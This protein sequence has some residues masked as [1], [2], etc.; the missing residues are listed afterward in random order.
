MK[1]F[2]V[3]LTGG[4]S[5]GKTIASKYLERFFRV[6]D[7]DCI[8][9]EIYALNSVLIEQI[10]QRFGSDC[11]HGGEVH[12][13][14]LRSKVFGNP[15][16]LKDLNSL[17]HPHVGARLKSGIIS[18]RKNS[19]PSLFV[20]PLLFENSWQNELD[21][22][23]LLGCTKE[24]QIQRMRKRDGS[25]KEE[26]NQILSSQMPEEEKRVL[27]EVYILNNRDIPWL[28]MQLK[29]WAERLLGEE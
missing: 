26:A 1:R 11:I 13:P 3:G 2:A 4:I 21:S 20:I 5:S 29:T 17:V 12:R 19:I 24:L 7:A 15:G 27:C 9:H 18:A 23:L 6:I 14:T 22:T 10:A 28:H 8:V 25:S 16:A